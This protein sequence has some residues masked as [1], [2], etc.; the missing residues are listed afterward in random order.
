[1][2]RQGGVELSWFGSGRQHREVRV[3]YLRSEFENVASRFTTS[4]A[5]VTYSQR[6]GGST[7][8]YAG[9]SRLN[10]RETFVEAGIRQN[11]DDIPR[12]GSG[13]LSGMVMQDGHGVAGIEVELDGTQRTRSDAN[14]RFAFASVKNGPHR[15]SARAPAGT[16]FTTASTVTA[17]PS[18]DVHFALA[19]A[20]ARLIGHVVD[21]NGAGIGGITISIRTVT[22]TTDSDGKFSIGT[23]A[24]QYEV[25]LGAESL[26]A[27][28]SLV[29]GDLKTVMLQRDLPTE[30]WF[31]ARANR[32]IAGRT[33]PH[34]TVAIPGLN[35]KTV[36]DGDG[37][38]VFRGLPAGTVRVESQGQSKTVDLP[39]APAAVDDLQL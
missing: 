15:V 24:G 9:V 26:P 17:E 4:I 34:A 21:D 16:Y 33:A 36:A 20:E 28:Y 32:S 11:L 10:N 23:A 8:V 27:G 5:S 22:A 38:F 6:V 19:T 39:A 35:R 37:R 30:V 2:R 13:T 25:R 7:D 29:S 3:R 12:F 18:D 14:G 31:R 1:M